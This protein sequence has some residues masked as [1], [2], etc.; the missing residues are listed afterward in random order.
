VDY[1]IRVGDEL[2][3]TVYGE[4][5]LSNS[6]TVLPG[7]KIV[8]PLVGDIV[9]AGQTPDQASRSVASALQRYVR[10]PVVTIAVTKQALVAV[11]VLGNVVKPEK[12]LLDP[13]S[14]LTDAIAAAQGL[15][16]TD[17]DYPDARIA[18][19]TGPFTNISLQRL[20][21]DGDTSLNIPLTDGMTVYIP[22]PQ[23]F[24]IVVE[25]AVSHPGDV[26]IHQGD[27]LSVALARA[28]AGND[29]RSD[30]NRVMV[31][32]IGT[33]GKPSQVTV[34]LYKIY[35]ANSQ[36]IT[37]DLARDLLMQKGDLVIVPAMAGH[38]DTVSGPSSILYSVGH[39][40]GIL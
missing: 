16:P 17:G 30:L 23:V 28:G 33:D 2:A 12:Y 3:I 7:G 37:K 40:F 26:A 11:L 34:N 36:D 39:L 14:R 6:V 4:K 38:N 8:L 10:G 32:R 27:R 35:N 13:Q 20:L 29:S 9:I 15:G 1:H 21:R 24:N 31:R 19:A 5:D 22:S 18:T 25:G